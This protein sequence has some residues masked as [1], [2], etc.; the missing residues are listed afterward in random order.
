MP[1]LFEKT[2]IN[3]LELN[4]RFVRS[5]TWEGMAEN[6]GAWTSQ[7]I[8]LMS[9]IAKGQVGLII[10]SHMYVSKEGQA[11][12]MQ[13]GIN[14]DE[15][16]QQLSKMTAAVNENG[17]KIVAQIAHAGYL[18]SSDLTGQPPMALS[19]INEKGTSE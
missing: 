4:N 17:G 7:L 19:I 15:R 18:T 16:I 8:N 3:G 6:D 13:M 11:T 12:P 1:G 5:A 14:Q 9:A 10:S 2:L